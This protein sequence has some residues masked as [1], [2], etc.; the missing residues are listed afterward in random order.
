MTQ[1][2][3]KK[4]LFIRYKH[5]QF[6]GAENYL[7]R[8]ITLLETN[9]IPFEVISTNSYSKNTHTLNIPKW[10]PSF[11]KPLFFNLLACIYA[12][13][14]EGIIFSLERV[15]CSYI[16]RAG[17]GVHKSWLKIRL[18]N[19]S[20]FKKIATLLNPIHP[21]YLYL[22]Y[23]VFKNAKKI[24]ANS[25]M[26]KNE[27]LSYYGIDANKIEVI[28]NGINLYEFDKNSAKIELSKELGFS[29][30][31]NIFLFVGSGFY[32]KGLIHFLFIISRIQ[33]P[34]IAIIIGKDKEIDKYKKFSS[35][36]GLNTFFLG[37]RSDIAKFYAASDIF[38]F[39]TLYEPFSNACLEAMSF[40]N[41][42]VS[43]K[44][45][46][47]CEIMLHK[48]FIMSSPKEYEIS[49]KIDA[50]LNKKEELVTM[51][52]EAAKHAKEFSIQKNLEKTLYLLTGI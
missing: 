4:I 40:G 52:K 44:Q 10:L 15:T 16:Y 8:L 50:L 31:L 49:K 2:L 26:V 29:K 17:D 27:I 47:F 28:Y 45:N 24:I 21:I 42:V 23:K 9:S 33:S 46:G 19:E 30:T 6:G 18:K 20:F 11:L 22:E 38:L 51:Q 1:K 12:K 13:K 36:M 32:R 7:Q 37:A 48:E 25:E 3:T 39:P 35:K 14:E 43:T 34:Y 41:I 5:T